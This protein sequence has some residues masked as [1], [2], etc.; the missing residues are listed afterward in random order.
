MRAQSP[1]LAMRWAFLLPAGGTQRVW[2]PSQ[3]GRIAVIQPGGYKYM[4]HCD[5]VYV[6]YFVFHFLWSFLQL[7]LFTDS[8]VLR[9]P[10]GP[11]NRS[12]TV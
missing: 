5:R 9:S 10:E 6:Q 2:F 3:K 4:D 7:L 11:Q 1:G 12:L 8:V